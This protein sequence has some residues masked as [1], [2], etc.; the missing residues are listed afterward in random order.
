MIRQIKETELSAI[1]TYLEQDL[2]LCLYAYIDIKKYGLENPNLNVFADFDDNNPAGI[3]C[4]IMKYYKGLQIYTAE[5]DY[6][7]EGLLEFLDTI[8]YNM[9]NGAEYLID[10]IM[11][12]TKKPDAYESET[13]HVAELIDLNW[14]SNEDVVSNIVRPE[15]PEDFYVAAEL[16]CSDEG[17]GGH[18]DIQELSDQL[19]SR[20]EEDFGR[21]VMLWQ[22]DKLVC[23]VAT[24][25][26]V[27]IAG[28]ISGVITDSAARG[29]GLAYQLVGF[30]GD[31][32]LKEGKRVFLFYYT[33]AAG[34]LY[35]K[36]GFTNDKNWKKLVVK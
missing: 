20:S 8:E 23:H 36:L 19:Q 25:A 14:V 9:I 31:E 30:L 17:L 28:V 3:H 4:V 1:L 6:N 34:K 22:N 13:G 7:V 24:Y 33:E 18:Y 32:L 15:T 29:Q 27:E 5:E 10:A 35:K 12:A 11:K 21:N 2:Q 26:E 16:I